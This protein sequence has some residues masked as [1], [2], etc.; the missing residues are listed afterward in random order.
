MMHVVL[1]NVISSTEIENASAFMDIH[2][3]SQP[4]HA[5]TLTNVPHKDCLKKFFFEPPLPIK[6]KNDQSRML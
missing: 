1:P 4:K 3:T 2:M 5:W 6:P